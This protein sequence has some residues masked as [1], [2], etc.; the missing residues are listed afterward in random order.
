MW[1]ADEAESRLV[2]LVQ[3]E[4]VGGPTAARSQFAAAGMAVVTQLWEAQGPTVHR[5]LHSHLHATI[6]EEVS[7]CSLQ[8]KEK[9]NTVLLRI[10]MEA[11]C[12]QKQLLILLFISLTCAAKAFCLPAVSSP[13]L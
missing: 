12:A 10:M 4:W 9:E 7:T 6:L 5:R 13:P 1:G 11:F 3:H 8:K 2:Q